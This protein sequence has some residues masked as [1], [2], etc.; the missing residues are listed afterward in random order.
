M[1]NL[2]ESL[3]DD[4]D[5]I[6]MN[7][8]SIMYLDILDKIWS[9]NIGK[10]AKCCDILGRKLKVGDIVIYQRVGALA[11]GIIM[12]IDNDKVFI[13]SNGKTDQ[14]KMTY[15]ENKGKISRSAYREAHSLMKIDLSILEQIYNL[16]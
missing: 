16:K 5:T 3:L 4:F 2:K 7:S 10:H 1:K 11:L 12:D 15:G 8:E 9:K 13:S 6:S 14:Y